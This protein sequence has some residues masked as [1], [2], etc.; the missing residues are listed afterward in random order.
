MGYCLISGDLKRISYG[1]P[2]QVGMDGA[3]LSSKIDSL[4]N[5]GLAEKAF[6]GAV[7][8]V[9]KDG[10]TVYQKAY[11]FHTYEQALANAPI[12]QIKYETGIKTDAMDQFTP[13]VTKKIEGSNQA[14]IAGL[15]KVD[16]VYDF[17][18]VTKISTSALALLQL[19]SEGKFDIN[20]TFSTYVPS[21]ANSNKAD[22][23]FKDMLTHR[24]GL[25]AWIPFWRNAVDTITTVNT[26]L[27]VNPELDTA[28][29]YLVKKP[30][31][32]KRLFGKKTTRTIQIIESVDSIKGLWEQCLLPNTIT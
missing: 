10:R 8:Q 17:A 22:L 6:P 5:L 9:I 16:D 13:A 4:V 31:F 29:I 26:A 18:S 3:I 19:T 15:V 25:K 14:E 27:L 7:V 23:V 12:A 30:S 32:F 24:S 21:L 1:I 2:E 11:G 20:K 28:F